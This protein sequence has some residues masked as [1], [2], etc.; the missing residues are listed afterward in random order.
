MQ[1]IVKPLSLWRR[2]LV[3]G[4]LLLAFLVSFPAFIFY[5]AGYRYDFSLQKPV[6]TVTGGFY[7]L[8]DAVDSDVYIDNKIVT[9]ARAFRNASYIQGLEPGLRRIHV[10]GLGLNTWVKE[11]VVY[12]HIVTEVE[13][14]NLPLVP[15]VRLVAEYSDSNGLAVIFTKSSSTPVL[16]GLAS[17][18]PFKISTSTA[19]TTLKQS[20]EFVLLKDL[21]LDKASTTALIKKQATSSNE[22]NSFGFSTST[23]KETKDLVLAT[24]TKISDKLILYEKSGEVWAKTIS[25][26]PKNI[27]RYFCSEQN[28]LPDSLSSVAVVEELAMAPDVSLNTIINDSAL[29][30]RAEIRIDNKWQT[31]Q[32]FD[33]FPTNS[34]LVL[35][36]LDDGIYVVE[37]DD[38]SWQNTQLLYPGSD[39]E[40]LIYRG[41]IFVKQNGLIFEVVPEI[42]SL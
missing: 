29:P 28:Q 36:H 33:F 37:V 24:T 16:S 30:C 14:F 40:F 25:S 20:A 18:T 17:T 31:V 39:L 22:T 8:A 38:R 5:A 15:Q 34:N 19:T 41:G 6:I 12:P 32:G 1:P 42:V 27:P 10:Q 4:T 21:F 23:T 35:M 9:N 13:S 2:K 3:F 26:E 7:I 11:L